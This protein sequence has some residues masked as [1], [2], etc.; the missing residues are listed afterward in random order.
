MPTYGHTT[1]SHGPLVLASESVPQS[2]MLTHD[3]F[4]FFGQQDA[5]G[6]TFSTLPC[7]VSFCITC[8]RS[9]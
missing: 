5:P 1:H 8:S 3:V 9:C 4:C 7:L 6:Q 2:S